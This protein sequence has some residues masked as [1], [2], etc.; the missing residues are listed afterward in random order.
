L[1]SNRMLDTTTSLRSLVFFGKEET[2]PI[3]CD[4][5]LATVCPFRGDETSFKIEIGGRLE[6]CRLCHKRHREG[7]TAKRLCEEWHS[8][9]D[10]LKSM[11]EAFPGEKKFYDSGTTKLPYTVNTPDLVRRL[12]WLRVK[13]AV[14]RRDR[15]TCQDCGVAFGHS[16]RKV[17]DPHLRHGKGG[18]RWERLE[19]HHIIPRSK[20]GSDHPG[21]LKTLCPDCHRKYTSELMVDVVEERRRERELVVML[22]QCPDEDDYPWDIGGD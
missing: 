15:F 14:L 17:Y 4:V 13:E 7:S 12:I 20:G 18:H 1:Q 6:P 10:V 21:N 8:V 9:K 11:R 2:W 5:D 3:R 19:V 16:R 22:R